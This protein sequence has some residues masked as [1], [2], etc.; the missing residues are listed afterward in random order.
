MGSGQLMSFLK[1]PYGER[2]I[3]YVLYCIDA[4]GITDDT[5]SASGSLKVVIVRE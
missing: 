1:S 5:G 3:K 2:S 4:K